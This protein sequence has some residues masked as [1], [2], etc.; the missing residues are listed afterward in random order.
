MNLLNW[1]FTNKHSHW[2][3]AFITTTVVAI[4]QQEWLIAIFIFAICTLISATM[5]ALIKEKARTKQIQEENDELRRKQDKDAIWQTY[6]RA[7]RKVEAIKRHR[8]IYGTS[9]HE[10]LNMINAYIKTLPKHP[11]NGPY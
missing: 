3:S 7:G 11:D 10:S 9:L 8:S 4:M 6:A 1:L 2:D 5:Q